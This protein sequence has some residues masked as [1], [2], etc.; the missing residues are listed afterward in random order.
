M[1]AD[2]TLSNFSG[3]HL[4]NK[5]YLSKSDPFVRVSNFTD[6]PIESE[7]RDLECNVQLS[8]SLNISKE[9]NQS[10]VL[11]QLLVLRYLYTEIYTLNLTQYRTACEMALVNLSV[12]V[13][14]CYGSFRVTWNM[15]PSTVRYSKQ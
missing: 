15:K 8:Y 9:L 6:E 2:V 4:A 5:D 14:I 7:V 11:P 10:Y 12:Q 13:S 3:A 1:L